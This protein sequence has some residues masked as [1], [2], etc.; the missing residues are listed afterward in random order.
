MGGTRKLTLSQQ[1]ARRVG[2]P[3]WG[4]PPPPNES[5]EKPA[6]ERNPPSVLLLWADFRRAALILSY[7]LFAEQK[8]TTCII[9]PYDRL[10]VYPKTS[11]QIDSMGSA[12]FGLPDGSGRAESTEADPLP[13]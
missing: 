8:R 11:T 1:T 9:I 4:H 7:R 12:E 5:E 13:S 3:S 6:N 2:F 10:L